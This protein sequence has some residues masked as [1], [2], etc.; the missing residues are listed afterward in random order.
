MM[1]GYNF[2]ERM[3]KCLAMAREE[4]AALYHPY[5]GTEHILLGMIAEGEGVA[6]TALVNL[7]VKPEQ[8]RDRMLATLERG[9]TPIRTDQPY[10]TRAKKVLELSMSHARELH[11]SYVGTEH[12]LLGLLSEEKGIAAEVLI[13]A[14]LSV[15]RVREEVVRILGTDTSNFAPADQ[16]PLLRAERGPAPSEIVVELHFAD[17]SVSRQSCRSR[18]EAMQYLMRV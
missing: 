4:A 17:G 14:G 6:T 5:V 2:T 11:H 9:R 13:D 15:D 18:H 7:S 12:L 10:T 8:L 16:A 3:R 1:K